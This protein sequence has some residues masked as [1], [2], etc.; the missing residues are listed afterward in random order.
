MPRI[1]SVKPEL[2][3]DEDIT[4]VSRDARLLFIGLWN[5]ADDEGRLYDKPRQIHTN[6]FPRDNDVEV[7]PLLDELVSVGLVQRWERPDGRIVLIIRNFKVHQKPQHPTPSRIDIDGAA[8]LTSDFT[9]AHEPSRGVMS[10]HNGEEWSGEEG[11]I[12]SASESLVNPHEDSRNLVKQRRAEVRDALAAVTNLDP[13]RMTRT[14]KNAFDV[15]VADLTNAGATEKL[16]IERAELYGVAWPKMA[17]TP[18]ALARRW[19]EIPDAAARAQPN[20]IVL[21]NFAKG[22]K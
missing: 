3:S 10:P 14:N 20:N 17:L 12:D 18:S 11:R 22:D 16:V 1:R 5:F 13:S 6:V 4:D 8:P 9:N 21:A 19:D 2:W 15:S 7:A